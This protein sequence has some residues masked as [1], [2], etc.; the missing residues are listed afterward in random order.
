MR[1]RSPRASEPKSGF[2]STA[3][4]AT[5]S[6]ELENYWQAGYFLAAGFL[7]AC[8]SQGFI[9]ARCCPWLA[10]LFTGELSSRGFWSS[11]L[12]SA[13]LLEQMK[14]FTGQPGEPS[15]TSVTMAQPVSELVAKTPKLVAAFELLLVVLLVWGNFPYIPFGNTVGLL[16]LGSASL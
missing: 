8:S 16:L 15:A 11:R 10:K 3:C 13:V 4:S 5:N 12:A 1:L 2:P 9:S 7:R 6:L 14:E